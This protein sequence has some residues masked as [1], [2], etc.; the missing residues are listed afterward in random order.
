MALHYCTPALNAEPTAGAHNQTQVSNDAKEEVRVKPSNLLLA[1]AF[2]APGAA[3]AAGDIAVKPGLWEVSASSRLLAMVPAL[4]PERLEQLRALA[5]EHGFKLPRIE[6]GAASS[7]LC[8]TP[9]M[10]KSDRLPNIYQQQTGCS[11][12]DA[13]RDGDRFSA[14]ISCSGARLRGAG[15]TEAML[16]SPENFT[17]RTSFTGTMDGQPINEHADINGRWVAASCEELR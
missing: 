1:A 2:L 14:E 13:R 4:P 6:N 16:Q 11:S 12:R 7:R 8:L 17:G 15:H 10:A 9:D 3:P 5:S